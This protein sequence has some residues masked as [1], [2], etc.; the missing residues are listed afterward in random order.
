MKR[1]LSYI[2]IA[3]LLSVLSAC[4]QPVKSMFPPTVKVQQLQVTK[5]GSWRMQVRILNNSYGGMNFKELH[6]VMTVKDQVAASIDISPDLDIPALSPG[7]T[8]ITI[9]PSPTAK[10]ALH[11]IANQ[12]SA[13]ALP[14]TLAGTAVAIPEHARHTRQFK[15]DSHDWLSAVPGVSHLFR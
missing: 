5:D 9:R 2:A 13:G 10:T 7:I 1:L 14:Y 8:E 15:V 11:A 4:G 12:G 3:T 6:L